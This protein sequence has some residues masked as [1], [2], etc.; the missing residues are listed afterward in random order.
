MKY[1]NTR[2]TDQ[3]TIFLSMLSLHESLLNVGIMAGTSVDPPLGPRFAA[4]VPVFALADVYSA[5]FDF[6]TAH[7]TAY[8]IGEPEGFTHRLPPRRDLLIPL[9]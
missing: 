8:W 9:S 7:V 1:I 4:F 6:I 3:I 2:L 5:L